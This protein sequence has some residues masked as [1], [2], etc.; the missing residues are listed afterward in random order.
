MILINL[1]KFSI[2]FQSKISPPFKSN[3]NIF[4]EVIQMKKK[5]NRRRDVP[6]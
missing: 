4:K 2:L 5:T 1:Q 3:K 6:F